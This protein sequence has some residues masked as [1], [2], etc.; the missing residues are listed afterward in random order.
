[1]PD[2]DKYRVIGL[3][4][5]WSL[6]S[7]SGLVL[8]PMLKNQFQL[9]LAGMLL[10]CCFVASH[11]YLQQIR[12]EPRNPAMFVNMMMLLFGGL[13]ILYIMQMPNNET[14]VLLYIYTVFGTYVIVQAVILVCR[15]LNG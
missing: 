15:R 12:N 4:W 5:F 10:L 7:I 9:F 6:L 8:L 1:L 11:Y 13:V 2:Y 3:F 14:T